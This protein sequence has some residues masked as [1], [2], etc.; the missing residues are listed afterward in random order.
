M[1]M[2]VSQMQDILS[3][4]RGAGSDPYTSALQQMLQQIQ[5]SGMFTGPTEASMDIGRVSP[6]EEQGAYETAYR[7]LSGD[8]ESAYAPTQ[9]AGFGA[10]PESQVSGYFDLAQPYMFG[11][12]MEQINAQLAEAGFA[13]SGTGGVGPQAEMAA[14]LRSQM[15]VQQGQA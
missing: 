7:G 12:G 4:R 6:Q 14:R 11:Q 8:I 5:S 3:A 10:L 9:E 1:T 13:P 2:A 15:G